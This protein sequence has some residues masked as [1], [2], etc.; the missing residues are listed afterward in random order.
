VN[1]SHA[2][3]AGAIG[4]QLAISMV[5]FG[6]PAL[7]FALRDE[8][9]V[10]T[11]EFAL[12]FGAVGA[13]PALALLLAGRLCDRLGARPVLVAG[14]LLGAS[15]LAAAGLVHSLAATFAALLVSGIG[16]AAVPV[17]GMTTIISHF[18]PERRGRL[19]GL[20]QM[21]VPAGGLVA[22]AML[23]A[24]ASVGGLR[25][26]FAV[27]AA[28]VLVT[29]L[30]FAVLAGP[31]ARRHD[32]P[33]LTASFPRPLRWL[34]LT[35][36]LYVTCLGAVLTFTVDAAHDAGMSRTA[37]TAVFAALNVGAA[38]ARIVWGIVADRARG[39]RRVATLSALGLLGAVSVLAFPLTLAAGPGF[40]VAG[41]V[42]V[43]FG[44]LGFNGVLYVI[45]GELAGRSAGVAVGAASTVV[46]AV[47]SVTP[48]L[49]GLVAEAWGFA[50]MFVLLS[51]FCLAGAVTARRVA[52][53]AYTPA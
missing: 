24:L 34:M 30:G 36:A 40:A 51:V 25:L 48:P 43:A 17:A 7:T 47:G 11:V 15:G 20:R 16:A 35:G 14:A 3:V 38:A 9:G 52:H 41:A 2:I 5:Q 6:M 42:L 37:A 8:R 49:F 21:A 32:L 31:G 27:P 29:G 39:T 23:P 10:S 53:D 26:A 19:L 4:S 45:A 46:F 44:T 50:A 12:L 28:L 18:G 13:G 33:A 22:A 1:R